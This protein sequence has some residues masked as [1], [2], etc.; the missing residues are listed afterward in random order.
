MPSTG[1]HWEL[2]GL[3]RGEG[4]GYQNAKYWNLLSVG[5]IMER[6]IDVIR[7]RPFRNDRSLTVYCVL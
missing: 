6:N 2:R 5:L 1:T 4:G 3:F 7:V